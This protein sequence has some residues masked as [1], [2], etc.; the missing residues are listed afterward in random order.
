[1]TDASAVT[2]TSVLAATDAGMH[3]L[4]NPSR[5]TSIT[6][7]ETWE[8]AL[9]EDDDI[10]AHVRAGELVPINIGGDGAFQFLVRVG[11]QGHAPELTSRESQHLL[12]SSQPYLYLSD[13]SAFLTGIE[14]IRADPGPGALALT[15]PAGP[16][17]VTIH[18]IDRDSEPGAGE[19]HGQAASE[20]LPDFAVLINP[21]S[22]TGGP[23]RTRLQTFDRS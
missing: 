21:A 13:G 9:L 19:A 3:T 15:I 17:A 10:T 4:W 14:H 5:F 6:S 1:M 2:Q 8:D 12:A 11:T 23:Y 7:Y 16:N 18:L 22:T 20:A